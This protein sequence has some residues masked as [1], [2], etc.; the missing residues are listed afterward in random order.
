MFGI[1]QSGEMQFRLGDIFSD[2]TVLERAAKDASLI[3]DQDPGLEKE[4][5]AYL[6]NRIEELNASSDIHAL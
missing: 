1:R 4:E 5:N 3:L 6:K 2:A